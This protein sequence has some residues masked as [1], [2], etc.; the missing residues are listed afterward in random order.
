LGW[1]DDLRFSYILAAL[2]DKRK[3]YEQF[4]SLKV[5]EKERQLREERENLVGNGDKLVQS[6]FLG[7]LSTKT[8]WDVKV[9]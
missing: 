1:R 2:G 4:S 3:S 8:G 7:F 6:G 5:I 9:E